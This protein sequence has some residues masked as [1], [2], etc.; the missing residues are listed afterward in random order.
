MVDDRLWRL[1]VVAFMSLAASIAL[2][3]KPEG[4]RDVQDDPFG[5]FAPWVTVSS[6]ERNRLDEGDVVV[7]TLPGED[8]QLAVLG[9]AR[10]NATPDRLVAWTHA[11]ADLKRSPYVLAIQRFSD[12]PAPEDLDGLRLD[13]RDLDAIRECQ[14]HDCGLKLSE[15]EIVLLRHAVEQGGADSHEAVQREFRRLL[16]ARLDLYRS[17]GL[18]GLPPYVNGAEPVQPQDAFAA[19]LARS[20]YLSRRLSSLAAQLE[21][22]PYVESPR[23]ESFFYWSKEVYGAGKPVI[24]VTHVNILHSDDGARV[25]AVFVAGKQIFASHY[26][27][28]AL[29]LTAVLRDTTRNVHYLAYL[30]RSQ[31]DLLGGVFGFLKRSVLEGRISRDTPKILDALRRRL[32]SGEPVG[33]R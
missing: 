33:K 2:I 29:G 8:G 26:M 4:V 31:L 23:V 5:F 17:K 19:I 28:A 12:P 22:Y 1:R 16:L 13:D 15:R 21:G 24:T 3:G 11:I 27:N 14:P 20:P 10:L 9:V 18:A 6:S 7:R 32:E 30:N 25:P